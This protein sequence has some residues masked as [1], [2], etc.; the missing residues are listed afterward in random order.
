MISMRGIKHYLVVIEEDCQWRFRIM[1]PR[2][3]S[4]TVV[5]ESS[6]LYDTYG[7]ARAMAFR[8]ADRC[9]ISL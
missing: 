2:G 9:G 8:F 4:S 6:C 3:K 1:R 7:M 5:Y